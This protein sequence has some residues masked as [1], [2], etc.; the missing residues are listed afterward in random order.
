MKFALVNGVKSEPSK[1]L[2]GICQCCGTAVIAKC[3]RFKIH[4]WAHKSLE[5]CDPWWEN[6]S[7]WHRM[8]KNYF[9]ISNQE[10]VFISPT[11][12][13]HIADIYCQRGCVLEIQSYQIKPEEMKAR[14]DFYKSMIWVVNGLKNEFDQYYFNMSIYSAFTGNKYLKKIRW[15]GKSKLFERWAS[16][17]KHVYLD[18][19]TDIVW[20][21]VDYNVLTKE[22]LVHAYEKKRFVEYFSC[23]PWLESN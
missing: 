23:Q 11:G 12:E 1:G 16:A 18:F 10:V 2:T 15:M 9:P 17:T 3:G 13:R 22:G 19:G 20:H 7:E 14:E 6:E 4:H 8:W 21:I 5:H